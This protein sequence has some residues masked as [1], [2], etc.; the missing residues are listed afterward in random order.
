VLSVCE[1]MFVVGFVFVCVSLVF[2]FV[3]LFGMCVCVGVW[4]VFVCMFIL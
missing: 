1:C 4:C 2:F 3:F